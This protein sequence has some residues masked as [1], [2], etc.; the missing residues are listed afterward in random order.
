[1]GLASKAF[2]V[3]TGALIHPLSQKKEKKG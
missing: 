1:V 2:G 3:S